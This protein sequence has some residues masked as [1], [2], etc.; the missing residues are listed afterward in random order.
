MAFEFG[1]FHEFSRT[2]GQTDAEAFAHAFAQVDAAERWGLD[3]VW[4]AELHFLP[5][6]SVLSAPLMIATAI[7][8]RTRRL[9]VGIA[10]QVLPLCHPLRLAEEVATLDHVSQGRLIFGV[11]RSGFARTYEAYGVPYGESRE[12]FAEVLEVLKRS[13]CD[14]RF[15]FEG[16][17]YKFNNIAMVPKPL[18]KPHPPLRI[19]ATSP[20]TF[21][22]IGAM[23][24]PIFVAVRLGTLEELGP[25]I[26]AYREA[27]RAAGHPGDGEVY[28]RVPVYVGGDEESARAD[29]EQS[30]M[31]FY[32]TLGAQVVDSASRPG[33]RAVER[34]A[35]RGQA[36]QSVTY[37]EA[38]RGKVIVGTP[39]SVTTR[40]DDLIRTLGLNGILA[41]LNCGGMMSDDKV[42]RSLQ[43]MCEEVAP[44]FRHTP[45]A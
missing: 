32:R 8:S 9:K 13:W 37:E 40:L 45:S 18:Q 21:P 6:R 43:L 28:L 38:L 12:R 11:G 29:P 27:Y 3:V 35:Q 1:I 25:D 7:A 24:L 10:V 20:D 41:E 33:A 16:Q 44:R 5:E 2:A 36:L 30:I 22:A 31:Q 17:Y 19:A 39:D 42:M 15:S 14:G 4:L 34:R 23:G 26:A